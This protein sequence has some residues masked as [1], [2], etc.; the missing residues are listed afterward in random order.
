VPAALGRRGQR[1]AAG[2]RR[3][4]LLRP[5]GGAGLPAHR[6]PIQHHGARQPA[7]TAAIA[8]IPATAW[9]PIPYWDAVEDD[10]GVLVASSAEVAETPTTAFAGT[11]DAVTA[12]LVVRRVRRLRHPD[13]GGQLELDTP[14]WRHHAL[15]TDRTEPLLTVEAEY[16]EHAVVEQ[17]IADLK[18]NAL[19]PLPSGRFGPT[20]P[21]SP[22]PPWRTT[23]AAP[24]P[25][26]P[27]TGSA[28]RRWPPCVARC[29]P[30]PAG[31]CTPPADGSCDYQPTG[32]GNGR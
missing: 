20:P 27:G 28:G 6:R 23:S 17:T 1:A 24:W 14:T 2:A 8:A 26:W 29:W 21:G 7:I 13:T 32:R 19:A 31:W 18:A 30:C 16:R 9:T 25:P 12:R 15:L 22:R 11:P 10:N 5:L 3:R 4:R